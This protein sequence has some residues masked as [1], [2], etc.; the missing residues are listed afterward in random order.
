[1]GQFIIT[2][3]PGAVPAI[4]AIAKAWMQTRFGRGVRLRLDE[5]EAEVGTTEA[6]DRWLYAAS[7]RLPFI[8]FTVR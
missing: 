8:D 7:H 3:G 4:A 6:L 2:L 1:M 5:V